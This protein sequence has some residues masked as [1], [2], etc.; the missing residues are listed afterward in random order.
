MSGE[1]MSE[2]AKLLANFE[3]VWVLW[4]VVA[5]VLAYR[6]PQIIKELF[7]GVGGLLKARPPKKTKPSDGVR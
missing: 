7:A 1:T 2:F 4:I 3:P 6:S 5:A